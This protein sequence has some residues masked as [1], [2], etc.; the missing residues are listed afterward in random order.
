MLAI[1]ARESDGDAN[2]QS[3]DGGLGLYQITA[4]YHPTFCAAKGPD[5]KLLVFDP[6]ANTM[7]AAKLLAMNFA[8]FAGTTADV[9]LPMVAS[10]NA[11]ASRVKERMR[12]LPKAAARE[13][14]IAALDPLTTPS[15]RG[16]PGDYLSDV[17]RR[18]ASFVLT[19]EESHV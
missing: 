18:R 6:V 3:P 10:F 19:P 7:Y 8:L 11:R 13:E 15:K 1:L 12:S 14:V 17:L 16:G 2:A 9:T 5:G 4:S